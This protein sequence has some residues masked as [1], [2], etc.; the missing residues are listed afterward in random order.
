[1]PTPSITMR[2]L[3]EILRLKYGAKLSH[4]QIARSLSISASVVSR[5]ANRASQLDIS[6]WPLPEGWD[7]AMLSREFLKTTVAPKKYA[8]PDWADA[9]KQLR[10]KTMT[11]QLLWE[12]YAERNSD[13]HYSY[14]HYCRLYKAWNKTMTPSMRQVHKAGEKLFID[15]CGPTMDIVDPDSGEIRTAQ[16][17]V[18]TM[19]LQVTPMLKQPGLRGLRTGS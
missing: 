10:S 18:A 6:Q 13:G 7:D 5:Y 17:F 19:G 4:R 15:Y 11:L 9:H 16:I 1:M 2:K 12:E 14:N 8:L 3:K